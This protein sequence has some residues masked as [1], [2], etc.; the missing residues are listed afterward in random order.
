V[1]DAY[2]LNVLQSIIEDSRSINDTSSCQKVMPQIGASLTDDSRVIIY[3]CNMFI[4]QATE[5]RHCTVDLLVKIACFVIQEKIF[6]TSKSKSKARCT[7]LPSDREKKYFGI[8]ASIFHEPM[9]QHILD[10][11]AGKQLS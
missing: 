3:G 10:T 6:S 2:T 9:E 4:I 7:A 5:E 1:S 8:K 11:N